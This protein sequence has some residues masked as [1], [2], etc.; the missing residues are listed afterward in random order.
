[1][2]NDNHYEEVE[3][4]EYIVSEWMTPDPITVSSTL[5]IPEAYWK[6]VEN[7]IR[8]LLVVDEGI[9]VGIVTIEDCGKRSHLQHMPLIQLGP[10]ICWQTAR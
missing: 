1:L 3:M 6:M 10:V 2:E 5:T 4:K 9:L 7:E 8:R